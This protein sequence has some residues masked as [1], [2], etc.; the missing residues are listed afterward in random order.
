MREAYIK[1]LCNITT[2]KLNANSMVEGGKYKFFTCAKEVY[3]I[4]NYSFDGEAILISGNGANVGYVHY[5]NGKFNA[6]QRTYVL[7]N[8]KENIKYIKY[9]LDY[10]IKKRF[11][12]EKSTSNTPYIVLSSIADMKIKL[13]SV[14][15]QERIVNVLSNVDNI[16]IKL[17][18]NIKETEI[19]KIGLMQ[20]LL[21]NGINTFEFKDSALGLIPKDWKCKS[22]K[23]IFDRVVKKNKNNESNNV[24]T[25][26]GKQGLINQEEY[27][28][29]IVASKNLTT[30]YLL[31]KGYY[32]YNKS[33]SNGYP[34]GATKI[35]KKYSNGVVSPLYICFKAKDGMIDNRFYEYV[36]ESNEY[37]N[38]LSQKVQEGARNHGLLNISAEEFFNIKIIYPPIEEQKSIAYILS[39]IDK[40]IELLNN[41]KQEYE[42]L[43]KGLMQQLLTG[44]IRVK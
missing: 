27:F 25:I 3:N 20:Q 19:Q 10:N 18:E 16:I 14:N 5:Y 12:L 26:S 4:D 31:E 28:N 9:Q 34:V 42:Q 15:E 21:T 35:L 30:Y 17:D 43:K 41:K 22:I 7:M 38:Q 1:E 39:N 37:Y 8:F 24:L 6:Y 44:K 36:F 40:K 23:E 13:P 2:G 33:Y 11:E 29:K 32:A